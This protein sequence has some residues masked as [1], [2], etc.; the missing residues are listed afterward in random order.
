MESVIVNRQ[1]VGFV[2][3]GIVYIVGKEAVNMNMYVTNLDH[4]TVARQEEM[5]FKGTINS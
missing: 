2:R 4:K 1:T 3:G 5:C